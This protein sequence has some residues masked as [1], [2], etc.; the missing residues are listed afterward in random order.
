MKARSLSYGV[1]LAR[2]RF[3]RWAVRVTACSEST[4]PD[5][6]TVPSLAREFDTPAEAA[7]AGAAAVAELEKGRSN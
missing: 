2:T 1:H 7:Q 3:D 4:G 6:V 5:V